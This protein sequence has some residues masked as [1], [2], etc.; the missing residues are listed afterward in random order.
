MKPAYPRVCVTATYTSTVGEEM[1]ALIRRLHALEVWN[2]HINAYITNALPIIISVLSPRQGND[3]LTLEQAGTILAVLAVIG[4]VDSRPRLGG[5]VHHDTHDLGTVSRI[6]P[7]G[8]VIVQF[9]Q[10]KVKVCRLSEL[11]VVSRK[12]WRCVQ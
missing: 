5:Q 11:T 10:G 6:T 4:G 2:P 7:K 1:V 9:Q 8:K 3:T 12:M